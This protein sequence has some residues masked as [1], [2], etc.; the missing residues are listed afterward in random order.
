MQS[1]HRYGSAFNQECQ[2]PVNRFDVV[3]KAY[4]DRIKYKTIG[5]TP[6]TVTDRPHTLHISH[7]ESYCQWEN[8]DMRDV[9]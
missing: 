1:T 4:V 2:N 8:N 7:C 9:G 5:I 3:N 6:N